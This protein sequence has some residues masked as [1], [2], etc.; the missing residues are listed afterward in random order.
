MDQSLQSFS[1]QR[2]LLSQ[3]RVLLRLPD[4]TVVEYHSCAHLA[5][6]I[7]DYIIER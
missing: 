2:R 4:Q 6:H 7:I 5:L 3:A 1:K